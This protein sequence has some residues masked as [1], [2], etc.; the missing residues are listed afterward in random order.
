MRALLTLMLLTSLAAAGCGKPSA[1]AKAQ[2]PQA[3]TVSIAMST[4]A[5]VQREVE[6]VGTLY[7][8]EEATV[9]AKVPGRI[10]EILADVGDRAAAGNVLAQID[11]TDY[12]L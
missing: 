8:D 5:P 2:T 11:K 9:S 3:V 1:E 10:T 7:G 12:E 4:V 6:I